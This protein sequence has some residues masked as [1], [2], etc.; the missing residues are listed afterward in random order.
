MRAPKPRPIPK[1]T[2]KPARFPAENV[3]TGRLPPALVGQREF[4]QYHFKG[5]ELSKADLRGR[6]FVDCLFE[7]CNLAG[8]QLD[9]A[10]LRN[11]A[12]VGCKLLGVQF[13]SCD[14]L[15]FGV[16]FERCLLD[17]A[18]FWGKWMPNTRFESC[19]LREV[20]FNEANLTN[21]HFPACD[22]AGAVF[23]RTILNGADLTTA[24]HLLLDLDANSLQ[25]ARLTAEQLP[26]LVQKYGLIIE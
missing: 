23:D 22:L 9:R 13:A 5:F 20:N 4:E 15:L 17:Y 1:P 16:H 2:P 10:S 18:S 25:K 14:D 7:D 3:L 11:V 26:A 19:A 8:T 12:F 24:Q 21:A 6:L